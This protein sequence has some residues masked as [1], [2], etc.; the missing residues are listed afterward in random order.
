MQKAKPRGNAC[1]IAS[2]IVL[3]RSLLRALLTKSRAGE[4]SEDEW[5]QARS[6]R[7]M[8]YSDRQLLE[9]MGYSSLA[10]REE[11]FP[12]PNKPVTTKL[13]KKSFRKSGVGIYGIG[14]SYKFWR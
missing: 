11:F 12:S 2:K 7:D 13:S 8:I 1:Q 6:L 5:I 3:N 10:V 9:Q 4:L 14:P